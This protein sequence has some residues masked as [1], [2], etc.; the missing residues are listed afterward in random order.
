[1]SEREKH[2]HHGKAQAPDHSKPYMAPRRFVFNVPD[3]QT[4]EKSSKSNRNFQIFQI[5]LIHEFPHPLNQREAYDGLCRYILE[6]YTDIANLITT[7]LVCQLATINHLYRYVLRK[8][9]ILLKL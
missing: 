4:E 9:K 3:V 6:T 2:D 8:S 5:P 1:M 7:V